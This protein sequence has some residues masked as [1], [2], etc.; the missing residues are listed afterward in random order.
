MINFT[1]KPCVHCGE[2]ILWNDEPNP[3]CIPMCAPPEAEPMP[4]VKCGEPL[5]WPVD[6]PCYD[7]LSAEN[8]ALRRDKIQLGEERAAEWKRAE[9]AE[10]DNAALREQIRNVA[11]GG[12]VNKEEG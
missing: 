11:R 5:G 9:S 12:A 4:C 10:A 1:L 7:C 2:E 6:K 8:A 3:H